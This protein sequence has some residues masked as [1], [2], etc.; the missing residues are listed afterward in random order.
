MYKRAKESDAQGRKR[1]KQEEHDAAKSSAFLTNFLKKGVENKQER[2]R[3]QRE[4]EFYEF[5]QVV[6]VEQAVNLAKDDPLSI[7]DTTDK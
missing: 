2:C 4:Y 7:K 3:D 5:P 6:E 1:R